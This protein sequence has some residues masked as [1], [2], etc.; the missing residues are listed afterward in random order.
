MITDEFRTFL[1]LIP[2]A[3]VIADESGAI[4]L[5]NRQT[6]KL[7]CYARLELLGERVESLIPERYREGHLNHRRAYAASPRLRP[8]G[9]GRELYGLRK[10]GSEFPVEISLGPL[11][12]DRG[13]LVFAVIRDISDRKQA[14]ASVRSEA[15]Q[16][17]AQKLTHTGSWA[18]TP[19]FD[20]LLHCSEEVFRLYGLDPE[21]GTPTYETLLE[22]IHPED[23]EWVRETTNQGARLKEERLLDYR[24]VLPDGTLKYIRSIRRPILDAAGDVVEVVGTSVDVTQNRRAEDALRALTEELAN[25]AAALEAANKELESFAYSVAHD[26]RAPLR[27]TVGYAELLQRQAAAGLDDKSSRY[28]TMILESSKR[29]GNLIDDLLAFSRIGRAETKKTTV[30]LQQLVREVV[31]ELGQETSGRDIAWKI[32]VLPV[33][34][35]DRSM[36]KVV[37]SNLVSN[38]VKFTQTRAP[39]EIEIGAMDSNQDEVEV[40]IKDNGVG[41]DMQYATKLFGVFQRLHSSEEFEGTGIGLAVVQ[42]VIHRHGGSVRAEGA[43]DHGA[44]FSFSL[45]T[46]VSPRRGT[47]AA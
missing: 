4:S 32:G 10:D 33:C 11:Q 13:A 12:S 1:E 6:E 42:R 34:Y 16:T 15:Y 29:M 5:V 47:S 35:G 14:E 28:L 36:L 44:T 37:L 46:V 8:M 31:K 2:D 27:H 43:V 7:F 17:E 9:T 41:F 39:A 26:L 18:S 21:A 25:R 3:A 24:I 22:R 19:L 23:R 40:F 45:P 30:D 38:A 20:K